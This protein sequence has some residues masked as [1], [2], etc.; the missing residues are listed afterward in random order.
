M[1][2]QQLGTVR[3]RLQ[4]NKQKRRHALKHAVDSLE[5]SLIERILVEGI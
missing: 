4:T 5:R 3:N 2:C 1:D